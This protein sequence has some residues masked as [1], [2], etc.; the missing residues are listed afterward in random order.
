MSSAPLSFDL[1]VVFRAAVDLAE[2]VARLSEPEHVDDPT[3]PHP[4]RPGTW[5]QWE[6]IEE[7]TQRLKRLLG[8]T[9][10]LGLVRGGPDAGATWPIYDRRFADCGHDRRVRRGLLALADASILLAG[11]GEWVNWG[12]RGDGCQLLGRGLAMVWAGLSADERARVLDC[13]PRTHAA[14][15]WPADPAADPVPCEVPEDLPPPA[16][17]RVVW[18]YTACPPEHL[19]ALQADAADRVDRDHQRAA[20]LATP[21][22]VADLAER[23]AHLLRELVAGV[24]SSAD[25]AARRVEAVAVLALLVR[26]GTVAPARPW[27]PVAMEQRGRLASAAQTLLVALAGSAKARAKLQ[28]GDADGALGALVEAARQLRQLTAPA[29]TADS[30]APLEG[31]GED[32]REPA[33]PTNGDGLPAELAEK[34]WELLQAYDALKATGPHRSRVLSQVVRKIDPDAKAHSYKRPLASLG[35]RKFV[36]TRRKVGSYLTPAGKDALKQRPKAQ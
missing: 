36:A 25:R 7:E 11:F 31:A 8:A 24:G 9:G 30:P 22:A 18:S 35:K 14:V 28:P 2:A 26:I 19:E 15:G 5:Q 32:G 33:N 13:L 23:A 16:E 17:H 3:P 10:P 27:P 6:A 21:A 29:A 4:E 1:P 20:R 12:M 34:E